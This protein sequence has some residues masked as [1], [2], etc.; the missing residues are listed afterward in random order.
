MSAG[1]TRTSRNEKLI[2]RKVTIENDLSSG[3]N[4]ETFASFSFAPLRGNC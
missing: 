2:S 1:L 4:P 3:G